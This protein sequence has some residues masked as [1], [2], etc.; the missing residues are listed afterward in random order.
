MT[1]QQK[2]DYTE[3]VRLCEEFGEQPRLSE[4]HFLMSEEQER[5]YKL[6]RNACLVSNAEPS[7]ADFLLGDI[8]SSI[9][10]VMEWEREQMQHSRAAMVARASR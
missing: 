2:R 10:L 4:V 7:R 1:K 5:E 9:R 6:Y 3:Y 8:P